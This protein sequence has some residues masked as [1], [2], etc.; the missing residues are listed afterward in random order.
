MFFIGQV[1]PTHPQLPNHLIINGNI[2]IDGNPSLTTLPN[3][4]NYNPTLPESFLYIGSNNN[5]TD[6]NGFNNLNSNVQIGIFLNQNLQSIFGFNSLTNPKSITIHS[7]STL[8]NINGFNSAYTIDPSGYGLGSN[9]ILIENNPQL[10]DISFLNNFIPNPNIQFGISYNSNLANCNLPSICQQ[11]NYTM[12]S[13]NQNKCGCN[14]IS[15]IQSICSG[16]SYCDICALQPQYETLENFYT[17][18][19][20]LS[21][22]NDTDWLS[23]CDPC[24]LEPG[25]DPWFGLTCNAVGQVTDINLPNNNLSGTLPTSLSGLTALESLKL[26]N[27]NVS[28]T[29]N[30]NLLNGLSSFEYLDLGEND[31]GGLVGFPPVSIPLPSFPSSV[32]IKYLYLD[33]NN[34]LTTIPTIYGTYSNLLVLNLSGNTLV[35]NV[36]DN[37]GLLPNLFNLSLN[38][39]ELSGPIPST[40]GNLAPHIGVLR[41]QENNLSGCFDDNLHSLCNIPTILQSHINTGNSFDM[42]WDD[43]CDSNPANCVQEDVSNLISFYNATNGANW[44][45]KSGWEAGAAGNNCDPCGLICG[46]DV[47]YGLTCNLNGRVME[48]NLPGNNLTGSLPSTLQ[49]INFLTLLNLQNNE[50]G[51]NLPSYLG[52]EYIINLNL[53]NN[54]FQNNIP[55]SYSSLTYL[56]LNHNQLTGSIP[57]SFGTSTTLDYIFLNDNDLCG[58]Y[59]PSLIALCT[60]TINAS[61]LTISNGNNFNAPWEE[62]CSGQIGECGGLLN[63]CTHPDFDALAALYFGTGGLSN[64]WTNSTGWSG[65]INGNCD[66]C[67]ECGNNSPWY[68]VTCL[69]NRVIGINLQTNNLIGTIPSSISQLTELQTLNLRDNALNG[70]IPVEIGDLDHLTTLDLGKNDLTGSIPPELCD[71]MPGLTSLI[72]HDNDLSGCYDAALTCFCTLPNLNSNISALNEFPNPFSTFCASGDGNCS[73]NCIDVDGVNDYLH[74][75][76]LGTSGDFSVSAWFNAGTMGNGGVEDRIVSFGPTNRLE[77]GIDESTGLLWVYDQYLGS[78]QTFGINLRNNNWHHVV[79][80]RSGNINTV[81]LDGSLQGSYSVTSPAYGPNFRVGTWTGTTGT[82]AYFKGKID[83]VS[84]WNIPLAATDITSL[85]TCELNGDEFGLDA[86]FDFNTGISEGNNTSLPLIIT[87]KTLNGNDLSIVNLAMNGPTSNLVFSTTGVYSDCTLCFAPPMAN[88]NTG[89]TS[90]IVASVGFVTITTAQINNGST[91]ACNGNLTFSFHPTNSITTLTYDCS[92]TGQKNV[93]L[94][95]TDANGL[96]SSCTSTF[97]I[98]FADPSLIALREIY[99]STGGPNWFDNSGWFTNCDPCGLINGPKWFGIDCK[100]NTTIDNIVIDKLYI[101]NN[102]LNGT[103]PD[104]FGVFDEITWFQVHGNPTLGGNIPPSFCDM[105]TLQIISLGNTGI[106]L[107]STSPTFPSNCFVNFNDLSTFG[108]AHNTIGHFK[109][110]LPEFS[111]LAPLNNLYFDHN[112]Y[113]GSIPESYCFLNFAPGATLR[114]N[115]NPNLIGCY[116]PCFYRF[117]T[118]FPNFNN[119]EISV[120]TGLPSWSN[121]C[122]GTACC[123]PSL[124]IDWTPIFGGTYKSSGNIQIIHPNPVI[125]PNANIIFSHGV[126]SSV[127]IPANF[128]TPTPPGSL[129]I[130]ANG[131]N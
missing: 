27:N 81:Y 70:S 26:R 16:S 122:S 93:T 68:G 62:F 10:T 50:I 13:V 5:L 32:P 89:F 108:T 59:D 112:Q 41:L 44:T 3:F 7:N 23:N 18:T 92:E 53:S 86:H 40:F 52:E 14:D 80:S 87:D 118:G 72:L 51:G 63:N 4:N 121:F 25:N 94:Y 39:N 42:E 101:Q 96:Q 37:L 45:N 33:N 113:S 49:D 82:A 71:L 99:E 17:Y 69:N 104:V 106:G 21:W 111:S 67:G 120:N 105:N 35:D 100:N 15:Q 88:C 64:L 76:N 97:E 57:N 74:R 22:I 90:S 28:G 38:H 78:V 30:N 85:Q 29:I 54:N 95:V 114:L 123:V 127:T 58:C 24:G 91:S 43:F 55:S 66:P 131:C 19:N 1:F 73:D 115:N 61:N 79:F 48:I 9:G 75:S 77:I 11:S 8:T 47:W 129:I 12:V 117:C 124:T 2:S 110:T 119:V 84:I 46:N 126:G 65:I 20:G 116:D 103:L 109:G 125:Q 128:S 34:F 31:F 107:G 83:D 130:Q 36:P 102:N 98:E 56:A 6:I 60:S